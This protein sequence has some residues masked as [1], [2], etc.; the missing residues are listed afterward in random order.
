VFEPDP[1]DGIEPIGWLLFTS[2]PIST[3]K[4]IER[5]IDAYRARWLIE[6][7]FKALKTGCAFEKLQLENRNAL[8]NAFGIYLPVAWRLLRLRTLARLAE[9]RPA[10]D[11]LTL[12]QLKAIKALSTRPFPANP[13]LQEALLAIA[14]IGGHIK[15]NGPP[16]WIV[17]GRGFHD[18]LI[19]EAA[20]HGAGIKM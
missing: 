12:L 3:P 14:R 16:G 1:P 15:N 2:E 10:T 19:A 11:V 20:F 13:T 17:L 5:V 18:V 6:E 4:E 9:A 7:F 8:L